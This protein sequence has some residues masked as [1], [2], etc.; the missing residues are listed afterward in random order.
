[1]SRA[2]ATAAAR[3]P[4]QCVMLPTMPAGHCGAPPSPGRRGAGATPR[5]ASARCAQRRAVVNSRRRFSPALA[6]SAASSG[7]STAPG[8]SP[9]SS[10][11]ATATGRT[12]SIIL[13]S[14]GSSPEQAGQA[15]AGR[16]RA[17]HAPHPSYPNGQWFLS[18]GR[19]LL[20]R[21]NP[22]SRGSWVRAV[23]PGCGNLERLQSEEAAGTVKD[24]LAD[25]P[26]SPPQDGPGLVGGVVASLPDLIDD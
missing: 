6:T 20:R 22:S 8:E 16:L 5:A 1:M 24:R 18:P 7:N 2:S 12:C 4:A 19:G 13:G 17:A 11:E 25:W 9:K 14:A 21:W 15:P 3:Y 10:A 26:L 23:A